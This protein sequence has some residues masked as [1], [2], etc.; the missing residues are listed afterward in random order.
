MC[1]HY[2]SF[3]IAAAFF[4]IF[5]VEIVL[6]DLFS[7]FY[8][9]SFLF[10]WFNGCF[11]FGLDGI[12]FPFI[13][14][15]LLLV[16]LCILYNWQYSLHVRAEYSFLLLCSGLSLLFFFMTANILLFFFLF[17]CLLFPFFL[18]FGMRAVRIRKVHASFLLFFYTFL[19]SLAL[20]TGIIYVYSRTGTFDL[21]LITC[22]LE[23][24]DT[25]YFL[26]GMFIISFFAK[27]PIIPLHN[28]LPEAHVEAP[29]ELSVLLAGVILKIGVY[30][31]LRILL[32]IFPFSFYYLSPIVLVFVIFSVLYSSLTAIS[33]SDIKKIIAYSSIAHMNISLI[34][35]CGSS[36]FSMCGSIFLMFSHGIVSGGLFFLIGMLYERYGTKIIKYYTGLTCVMPLFSTLFFLFILANIGFPLTSGFVGET[37]ILIGLSINVNLFLISIVA[38]SI[39]IGSVYSVWMY[40]K[41]FFGIPSLHFV[42]DLNYREIA[43]IFP[44]VAHLIILGLFPNILIEY[45][46]NA[47]LSYFVL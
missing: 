2:F 7:A 40:N 8:N 39:F 19:G 17:E 18:M 41:L 13:Y 31:F 24:G 11:S 42:S 26:C 33:Q 27:I 34:G 45:I 16:P 10:Y 1:V 32:P 29:T 35:L 37:L 9:E 23:S 43:I 5:N 21:F 12:S 46:Y 38:F 20:L 44:I 30:G 47:I 28:W 25:E 4:F 15:T 6:F 22:S 3:C 36:I 14:L